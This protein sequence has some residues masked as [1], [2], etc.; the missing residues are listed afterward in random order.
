[1]TEKEKFIILVSNDD[2][3]VADAIIVLEGDGLNRI[4]RVISLYKRGWS[5]K[6]IISGGLNNRKRGNFLPSFFKKALRQQGISASAILVEGLSQNTWEQAKNIIDLANKKKWKRIILVASHYHQYR[7]YLTF[8]RALKNSG[9]KLEIINSPARDLKWF[10]TNQWGRRIDLLEE[11]FEKIKCYQKKG[12]L[13]TFKEVVYY[14]KWKEN[15]K[16]KL[17]SA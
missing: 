7:A 17:W 2:L 10:F 12:H 4:W 6:I 15:K 14:Q 8:L 3:K 5:K 9:R 1:M 13:V 11:E 16:L